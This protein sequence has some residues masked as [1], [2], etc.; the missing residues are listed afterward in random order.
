MN[1]PIA[2]ASMAQ[3]Q[4]ASSQAEQLSRQ[5]QTN[6]NAGADIEKEKKLRKACEGFE[7][8]FIQKMWES[9]R[10]SLPEDGLVSGSKEEKFWQGMYDQELSKSIA[11]SGG[12]GLTD[13]MMSQL[14]RNLHSASDV[15]ARSMQRTPLTIE[16]APLMAASN[17][18]VKAEESIYD[19]PAPSEGEALLGAGQE[20]L[21][22][23][24]S[25]PPVV[26]AALDDLA[27]QS[28]DK[29]ITITRQTFVGSAENGRA[30]S[31][32]VTQMTVPGNVSGTASG[33]VP[34]GTQGP[35]ASADVPFAP[36]AKDTVIAYEAPKEPTLSDTLESIYVSKTQG[37]GGLTSIPEARTLGNQ[38]SNSPA[39]GGN[40]YGQHRPASSL[41]MPP[42][43]FTM[44][45]RD[46]EGSLMTPSITLNTSL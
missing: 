22:S 17:E 2:D 7:A 39:A 43:P 41:T 3:S 37:Q 40:L 38:A 46:E 1:V 4:L 36:Y 18:E 35:L 12:I 21:N 30:I 20:T 23:A 32:Q 6:L 26:Q 8:I 31:R 24:A 34:L 11:G 45:Q 16:P 14:S 27:R 19:T 33:T 10:A 42:S 29:Q 44:G 25:T 13:M 15:A 28:A 5:A 9:M